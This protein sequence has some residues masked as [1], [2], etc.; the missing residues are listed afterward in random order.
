MVYIY[1]AQNS[2]T[3]QQNKNRSHGH[4]D[5]VI[6][7]VHSFVQYFLSTPI[8]SVFKEPNKFAVAAEV[9]QKVPKPRLKIFVRRMGLY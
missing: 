8:F 7:F 4:I 9:R 2:Y 3:F 5:Q 1:P 6:K